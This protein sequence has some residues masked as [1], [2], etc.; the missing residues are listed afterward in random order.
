IFPSTFENAA[1]KSA[2]QLSTPQED[3]R[4]NLTTS[5][6]KITLVLQ[7]NHLLQNGFVQLAPRKSEMFPIPSSTAD[8]QEWLPNLALHELRHVA[9]FDKLT[10]KLKAPFFEQLAFALYGLNL[11]AWYFE[12]DAVQ[13]ETIYSNG[14]RGRLPSWEM[15]IRANILSGKSYD[16][17]KYVLGSFRDNVPSYYTIGFFMSSYLT[18]HHGIDSH[19]KILADMRGKLLRPFN[20]RRAVKQVSNEKPT[21]IFDN[22]I[23]ELTTKWE[24]E[25]PVAPDTPNITTK[26]S[27]YP[28]DYLLPQMNDNQELYILKSSPTA[29]NEI[30][31]LDSVGNEISI[32]KTGRQITPYFHLRNDELVWDEYR[33]HARFGKQTYNIINVYNIDTGRTKTLTKASRYYSPAFHPVRDEIVVV[34]VNPEN[35]SKL[36]VLDSKT[37]SI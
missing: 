7:G 19:E 32:V 13:V 27:R 34:E 1:K 11:P 3:S 28:S 2:S 30:K 15:P 26:G 12:G 24:Q 25:S 21:E 4:K 36:I 14:G 16:F 18:N 29:V 23:A 5:P 6:P 10:G 17:N 20:F 31:R 37:G 22:T 35:I 8:N 33:K 9:Q